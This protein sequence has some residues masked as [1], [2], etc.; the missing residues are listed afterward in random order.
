[1][2]RGKNTVRPKLH[3]KKGDEVRVISGSERGKNGKVLRIVHKKDKFTGVVSHRAVVEGLN[4]VTKHK[5]PDQQNPQGAKIEVEAAI[6][7]SNLMLIEPKTKVPTR[8]GRKKE[9]NGWVRV[10]KKTGEIIK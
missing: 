6:H 9:E 10:S 1:M 2:T 5:K 3:I 7:V 4:M 8:I